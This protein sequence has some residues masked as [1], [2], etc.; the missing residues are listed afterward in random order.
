M[1]AAEHHEPVKPSAIHRFIAHEHAFA[2]DTAD[3]AVLGAAAALLAQRLA[4][5]LRAHG[6]RTVRAELTLT[7]CDGAAAAHG[8]RLPFPSNQDFD[9][10]APVLAALD[11]AFRRRV[12]VRAIALRCAFTPGEMPQSDFFAEREMARR[13]RLYAALDQIRRRH[14]FEALLCARSIGARTPV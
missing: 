7:Y 1:R 9:F 13:S 2:G 8:V 4:A 5:D 3:P 10:L 12:R 11:A 6:L 14:G